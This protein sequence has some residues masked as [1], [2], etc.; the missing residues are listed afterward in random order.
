[1]TSQPPLLPDLWNALPI[2]VRTLFEAM[3]R[4]IHA[5]QHEMQS[6]KARLGSNS[7]NSSK[8]SSTDPI[9]F[10]RQPPQKPTGKKRGGQPGHQRAT[11]PLV[12]PEQLAETITCRPT[13]CSGCGV[14]LDGSDPTP[15]RH[16]VAEIPPIRP[17]VVEYQVHRLTCPGCGKT[18]RGTL[19]QGVPT[20]SFGPRLQATLS[21]LAGERL[22]KRP[23]QRLAR[24]VLGL[25]I[26]LGMVSKLEAH[27]AGVL[28]GVDA[29]LAEA[30]RL[31]P[32]A[33]SDETLW[34]Q[35]GAKVWL[36]IARSERATHFRISPH[37]DAATARA[38]LG[39]DEGKVVICD[40][41][42]G[43]TWVKKK[44]WC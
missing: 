39:T 12:P 17:T 28:E 1:M 20:G 15:H 34:R 23:I 11:R 24:H 4:Q 9:H 41:Y 19:P 5:L 14:A 16:Q 32:W 2:E 37:R 35:A 21:L 30:V 38:M 26:S 10:Q 6:L 8:P 31:D 29:E 25:S 40:R 42:G 22:A 7:R 33:H 13:A 3:Q 36:W 43:Y 44:Q 27:T 18:T